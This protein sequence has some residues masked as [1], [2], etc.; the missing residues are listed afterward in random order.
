MNESKKSQDKIRVRLVGEGMHPDK[1]PFTTLVQ[2]ITSIQRLVHNR[3]DSEDEPI[4]DFSLLDVKEGSAVFRLG[5]REKNLVI[6]RLGQTKRLIASPSSGDGASHLVLKSLREV[7]RSCRRLNCKIEV[8]A[9]NGKR[10]LVTFTNDTYESVAK[11]CTVRGEFSIFGRV[12]RVG[13]GEP[14]AMLRLDDGSL[15]YCTVDGKALLHDLAKQLDNRVVCK[16]TAV[17]VGSNWEIQR[18]KIRSFTAPKFSNFRES[19]AKVQAA[20]GDSDDEFEDNDVLRGNEDEG[21]D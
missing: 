18:F 20:F 21:S 7:S 2:A 14:K 15:L 3:E 4:D 5:T 8:Y 11:H 9:P 6:D 13:G 12:M 17:W 10:P 19:L 16:G 1:V